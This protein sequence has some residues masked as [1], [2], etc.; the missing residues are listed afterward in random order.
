MISTNIRMAL[1]SI[2]ASK[3]RSILTTL[4]VIIG[5]S[6]VV[7]T[8]GL[9]EG[10]RNQVINQI[11]QLGEDII[12]VK[13]G[14]VFGKDEFGNIKSI[15]LNQQSG[16][17]TLTDNDVASLKSINGVDKVVPNMQ[18]SGVI[19]SEKTANYSGAN[20]IGTTGDMKQIIDSR[21]AFGDFFETINDERGTNVAI[22][23]S[24]VVNE[25][26]DSR[27]PIGQT[28]NIR[29]ETFIVRGVI[30]PFKES[31]LTITENLNKTVYIPLSVAKKISKNNGQ[32]TSINVKLAENLPRQETVAS[33]EKQLLENHKNQQDFTVIEKADFLAA[34]NANFSQLTA[35]VVAIAG[36]SL[37]VGGIGIMNIMLVGVSERTKEIGV[38][39]A[40]GATNQQIL[41]QFLVEATVI[42]VLG[43]LLGIIVALI[44][45]YFIKIWTSLDPVVSLITVGLALLVSIV[46]GIIFGIAPAIQ[47]ARKDPIQSLRH[48]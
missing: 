31:P 34:A 38:R 27:D 17:S 32:I 29:G 5:V 39:K 2:K 6:S 30:E 19:T 25:L 20:I 37:I 18:I 33:I 10:F 28:I 8:V 14:Q 13:S 43:G 47:A 4:G 45:T 26:F 41:S 42:S 9:A 11:N 1:T 23:G 16:A 7:V 15:N 21:L 24:N 48:E 3:I 44:T 22:L 35:F 36:T 46:V 40:V 12:T